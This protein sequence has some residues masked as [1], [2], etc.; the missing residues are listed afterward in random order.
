MGVVSQC[1][2]GY[3]WVYQLST[4]FWALVKS[5]ALLG[6]IRDTAPVF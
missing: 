2:G 6:A 3:S 4:I 5:S 1:A